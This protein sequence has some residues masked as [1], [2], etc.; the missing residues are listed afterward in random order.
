MSAE[1]ETR[2][3][4]AAL[5]ELRELGGDDFVADLVATFLADAP[6]LLAALHGSEVDEV[7]RAAHTLKSNGATFGATCLSELCRELE[8][9]A[10]AGDL[11]GASA[12]ADRID[13]EYA[14]V[15]EE[16]GP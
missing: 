9:Q 4:P 3:D 8:E 1:E 15:V 6:P 14:L 2:L 11:T 5:D 7:R 12:L 16:L 10:K 13:E